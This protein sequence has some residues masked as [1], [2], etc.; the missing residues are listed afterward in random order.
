[1]TELTDEQVMKA[2]GTPNGELTD[3]QVMSAPKAPNAGFSG[4]EVGMI[5]DANPSGYF[6]NIASAF[7]SGASAVYDDDLGLSDENK[8]WLNDKLGPTMKGFNEN[9]LFPAV[10][11]LDSTARTP[12]S[13][14]HAFGDAALAA[15]V[16]RDFI[17]LAEGEA[18]YGSPHVTGTFSAP[19]LPKTMDDVP[20]TTAD[21]LDIVQKE[22]VA[23]RE[24]LTNTQAQ[25]KGGL[26]VEDLSPPEKAGEAQRLGIIGPERPEPAAGE[27]PREMAEQAVPRSLNTAAAEAT[28][29]PPGHAPGDYDAEGK[30]WISK[31][32]S[33]DSVRDAIEK[34]ATTNDWFPE[35][36]G[37]VVSPASRDAVARAA[38]VE[39]GSI[40]AEQFSTHFDNDGKVRAVVQILRQTTQDF[41]DASEKAAKDPTVENAAAAT[42]AELRHG[43][44]VEYTLGL[45]AESG[46]SLAAWKDLLQETERKAASAK[47]QAGEATGEHPT[48]TADLV[49]AANDTTNNL[50]TGKKA[51]LMNLIE[52]AKTFTEQATSREPGKPL[53]PQVASLLGDAR[54]LVKRFGAKQEP[55]VDAFHEA[56]QR[57]STGDGNLGETVEAARALIAK[58]S[59]VVRE[60]KAATAK[61]KLTGIASRLVKAADGA[62]EKI[63]GAVTPEA[64]ALMETARQAIGRLKTGNMSAALSEFR[65]ALAENDLPRAQAAANELVKPK[66][67]GE[68]KPPVEHDEVMAAARRVA[69][70]G[71]EASQKTTKELPQDIT[72][73]ISQSKQA[74]S[75]LRGEDQTALE[76]LVDQA[77]K[78]AANMTKQGQVKDPVEALPPELQAL[79]NKTQRVVKSF[80]GI[81]KGEKAALLLARTGRTAEEQAAL[82]RS[83]HGL[84]PNQVASVLERLRNSPEGKSQPWYFWLWQ[85][86]LIS[87]LV[88]HTKYIMVNPTVLFMERVVS[89]LIAAGFNKISGED[90]SLM[91]PIHANVALIHS[92]P[93]ALAGAAQAFKTGMRVPL[94]SELNLFRRG[95][96]SPQTKGAAGAYTTRGPDWGIWNRV[97]NED[98]L[99]G[100]AKVLGVPGRS[101][102]AQHTFFK[103]LSERASAATRAYEATYADKVT[104]DKFW[105]RY[106]FHL[107]NPSDDALRGAVNDAYSGAFMA[108]LGDKSAKFAQFMTQHPALKWAFPFQYIPL[109]I[110]RKTVEYSPLAV[111]GKEMRSAIMGEKGGPAQNLALARMTVGSSII[112]YFVHKAMAGEATG[113]YPHDAKERQV[114]A[115]QNTQPNSVRVGNSWVSMDR[116][117]P[118]G[119][120]MRLGAN[121]GQII[122]DYDGQAD[123]AMTG[124]MWSASMAA[125]N[126][127]G[128][129]VGFQTL[130]NAIRAMESEKSMTTFLHSE[131]G[132]VVPSF[133]AQ[134]ASAM[135]PYLRQTNTLIDALKYRVPGLRETL[136]PKLDPLYGE[137]IKNPGYH[138]LVRSSTINTDPVKSELARLQ[139]G[140]SAPSDRLAN[141]KLSDEMHKRLQTVGGGLMKQSLQAVV[142]DPAWHT[143]SD[144]EKETMLRS[145]IQSTRKAVGDAMIGANPAIMDAALRQQYDH[146]NGVTHTSRPKRS[147]IQ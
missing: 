31:I 20:L 50:K 104:G 87:G 88:T 129:E 36:R 5:A 56:L 79:I 101:A 91:A 125:V 46:R 2:P 60:P 134:N 124:A 67:P 52:K 137:P 128:D 30:E 107:N 27:S 47:L 81:A 145:T 40:D 23:Q 122:K 34:V 14:L 11:Y 114:W 54:N 94:E 38:G 118:V 109:N 17:S 147:A 84:T 93:D 141:V 53:D 42:E 86:G 82:A 65:S 99:D 9:Y 10:A 16:P 76:K 12:M 89:P 3:E 44:V 92:I 4:A 139:I 74:V 18:F 106:N 111:L 62:R 140:V 138:T 131:A 1:M 85:Q 144:Y 127:V 73:L 43:H 77:E 135:D 22:A 49:N 41:V 80:G 32:D 102:N 28:K 61:S 63:A 126:L 70:A 45:R 71:K 26:K 64:Q 69:Q 115:S 119:N 110:A 117:G 100:A 96:E 8:K 103:I 55:E 66:A 19:R 112:G 142:Q 13:I 33:P 121:L 48:G 57:L 105:D 136:P 116:L 72:D 108:K 24:Q 98:Q 35:A 123:D 133:F 51:G 83:V 120:I 21:K 25:A 95:E 132:T 75:D 39:P 113:D 130:H 90:V 68:P 15:G 59:Q 146:F 7:K 58:K 143:F 37:G 97:F 6:G 29:E 78:Q